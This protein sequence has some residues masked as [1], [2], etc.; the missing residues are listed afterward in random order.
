VERSVLSTS[1]MHSILC[2]VD[3]SDGSRTA[4]HVAGQFVRQFKAA[5]HVLFVEDP[6]LALPIALDA[7]AAPDLTEELKQF[8]GGTLDV[9]LPSDPVLHVGT[10]DPAREIVS[11]ADR[12]HVDAIVMG[13][14][15]LTGAQKAF[16]GST[17]ARVL[18]RTSR[19]LVMVPAAVLRDDARNLS[20]LGS[21]LVLTDFGA[22]SS[23]AAAAAARLTESVGARL[24]LVHVVPLVSAPASW[25]SRA[26]AAVEC[27]ETLAHQRMCR[28]M[29]PLERHGPVESVI[30]Q[31][32]IA[33][34]VAELVQS[35]HAGLIVMGLDRDAHGS[36]PGST[37]NAVICSASV[38]V[39]AM[40]ATVADLGPDIRVET[41][42]AGADASA[43]MRA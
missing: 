26:D 1:V 2:P 27:R 14:H 24:V 11:V 4:L 16:C 22:A 30:L 3:F 38:P 7:L 9:E 20:G 29:A 23:C 19:T 15:G 43:A 31:G 21:I 13:T 10:G 25:S 12:E 37:A 18:R 36:H 5:L 6:L 34:R 42:E 28:A 8:I 35:R 33:A 41:S 40:P 32:N 17:T 39:L